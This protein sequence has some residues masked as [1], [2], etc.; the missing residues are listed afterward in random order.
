MA[1]RRTKSQETGTRAEILVA[2]LVADMGHIWRKKTDDFGIDGEIEIVDRNSSP[3]GKVIAVQVKGTAAT[4]LPG[5]DGDS[6][7]YTCKADDLDYWSNSNQPV[8]LVFVDVNQERAWWKN[9]DEWFSD[10]VRRRTRRVIF[11][12]VDDLFGRSSAQQLAAAA[13]PLVEPLP[14]VRASETLTTNLLVVTGIA[15][16]IHWAPTTLTDRT[17][18]WAVMK[19]HA[20]YEGGFHLSQGRIYSLGSF[21][22][23]LAPLSTEERSSFPTSEWSES[24][25]PDVQRTFVALLNFT[26]RAM[27]HEELRF[28]RE[29]GYVYHVATSNLSGKKV[30]G[31]TGSGRTV[32]KVYRSQDELNKVKFC[33]HYAAS[34]NFRRWEGEWYL[35]ISP[36]YHF[37]RD[38][39]KE[40]L[41]AAEY[42]SRIKRLE[43]NPAVRG[44]TVNWAEFLKQHQAD[45]LFGPA[46]RRIEFGELLSVTVDASIDEKA[47]ILPKEDPPSGEIL[48]LLSTSEEMS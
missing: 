3:T 48:S 18:A 21:P 45:T 37:T 9:L 14:L 40:S 11:D 7:T 8:L 43:R 32:F 10:P 15:S 12:K 34:L 24:E 16:E 19:Q 39:E 22:D 5:E 6:F 46:D 20:S 23:A 38:G 25:N 2:K 13:T 42:T 29:R 31:K 44:L 28:S 4:A 35:E 30:K 17:E 33:R 26:L 41:Y 1:K 27:H 47:W 36:T